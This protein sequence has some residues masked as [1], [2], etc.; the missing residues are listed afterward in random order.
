MIAISR[1]VQKP[2]GR[3]M[4]RSKAF[5][6]RQIILGERGALIRQLRLLAEQ[7]GPSRKIC[8]GAAQSPP[9]RR[10]GPRRRSICRP[11]SPEPRGVPRQLI[12]HE[13]RYEIIAVIVAWAQIERQVDPL[14]P[15]TP[16]VAGRG[17]AARSET[18]RPHPESTSRGGDARPRPRSARPHH[19][20]AIPRYCCPD[21]RRAPS[22]PTARGP[23]RRSAR[24]PTP[25]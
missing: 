11:C 3:I 13:G 7:R 25:P 10:H 6:A 18:G 21:S 9:A 4:M 24:T 2:G 22:A 23:A 15:R 14:P 16:L 5:L 12:G 20:C 1:S 19:A 8:S 17:E